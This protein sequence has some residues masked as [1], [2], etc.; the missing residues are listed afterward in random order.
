ME[1]KL[2]RK[3]TFL[4]HKY[5]ELLLPTFFMVTSEKICAVIDVIIIGFLLGSTQL[6]VINLASPLTYVT[7]IFYT[8]FGQG[9]NLLALRAQS[10]LK[11]EK[12]NYYFTIS[13]LGIILSTIIYLLLIFLFADNIL[14]FFNTPAEIY[15]LS[16]QYL[17]IIIFYYPLNSFIL[18][19]SF[20]IRADGF[21]KMPFYTVL[22]ANIINI[23]LDIAFLKVFNLGIEYT[24]LATVLGYLIGAIYISTYIIN[25]KGTFR[26]IS[27][28]KFKINE[29][30]LSLKEIILNTP[31]AIG[32]IFFAIKMALLT[33]LCSTYWGVA[34]LLAFLVYDNS[35]S[36]VYIFLSGVMKTMSP[37]VAV[38]HKEMDF[39]AVHYIIVKSLKYV[40]FVAFPISVLLFVYPEIV[41]IIFN[42]ANP[43][44]AEVVVLAIRI[45]SFSLVGR[46]LSY[47]LANY[48]QAIEQNKISSIITFLEEFLFAVVGALILTRVIGGIGI[49]VSILVAECIPV[50]VYIIYTIRIQ[51]HY[52]IQIDTLFMLQNSKLVAW[53]YKRNEIGKVDKYLD[54]ES[55]NVLLCIEKD[56]KE[57]ARIISYSMNEICNNIFENIKDIQE[58]DITIRL[59]EMELYIVLTC[60][61]ELYNPLSNDSLMKSEN[62]K[63]LSELNCKLDYD[64]ILGFN[65]TYIIFQK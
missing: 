26:L 27:L 25:K 4:K 65:R 16:K 53:T 1:A 57:D 24:A 58:I 54:D 51:K 8:L 32:K 15:E 56:F 39:E 52:K 38:L 44:H 30:I 2:E 47:L 12:V 50:F 41:L 19:V 46:C 55:K 60:E 28:A 5:N 31:E 62:V 36:F 20:F 35:E 9:G 43:S 63:K 42:V 45:T 18:V 34:G 49:W 21:P 6:S 22:I 40:V 64:E 14:A 10:Q 23:I 48:A 3:Y 37:I 61:G 17:L 7:G 11:H 29:I 33:Y 59:I 13:V